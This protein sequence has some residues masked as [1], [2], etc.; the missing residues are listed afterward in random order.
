MKRVQ[1]GIHLR[2]AARWRRD[3]AYPARSRDP[4]P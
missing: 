1:M 4:E 2:L 3:Q